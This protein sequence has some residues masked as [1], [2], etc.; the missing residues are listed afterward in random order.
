MLKA[1]LLYMGASTVFAVDYDEPDMSGVEENVESQ[2]RIMHEGKSRV[3]KSKN[4]K[5]SLKEQIDNG[6]STLT[7]SRRLSPTI[8]ELSLH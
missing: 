2:T 3:Q 4:V 1:A 8:N 7:G 5:T 6:T